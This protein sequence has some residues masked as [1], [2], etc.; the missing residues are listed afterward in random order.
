MLVDPANGRLAAHLGQRLADYALG[1]ESD[2][3]AAR[4]A[5]AEA[6]FQTRRAPDNKEVKALRDEVVTRLQVSTE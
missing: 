6:D 3:D 4:R 1:N 5:R 2:P